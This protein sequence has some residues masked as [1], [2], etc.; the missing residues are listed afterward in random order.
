[1]K[2]EN[3]KFKIGDIVIITKRENFCPDVIDFNIEDDIKDKSKFRIIK[4]VGDGAKIK[5]LGKPLVWNNKDGTIHYN[6]TQLKKV[7]K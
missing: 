1:M 2:L 4:F 5:R 6:L 3:K 7:E